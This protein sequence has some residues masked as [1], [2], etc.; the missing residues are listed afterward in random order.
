MNLKNVYG[1]QQVPKIIAF[2]LQPLDLFKSNISVLHSLNSK[3]WKNFTW[4]Y[5]NLFENIFFSKHQN[6]V[7]LAMSLSN[8]IF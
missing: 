2:N 1:L 7:I 5:I 8:S 3:G 6:E 4:N